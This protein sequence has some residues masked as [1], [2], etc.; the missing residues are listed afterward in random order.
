MSSVLAIALGAVFVLIIALW[1]WASR[2]GGRD[3]HEMGT[4]SG[5]WLAEHRSQEHQSDGR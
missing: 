3:E 2:D 1:A 5:Q 4:I